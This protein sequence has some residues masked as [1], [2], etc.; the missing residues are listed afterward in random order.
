V[1]SSSTSRSGELAA[2]V[3]HALREARKGFQHPLQGPQ[4][5]PVGAG[6]GGHHQVLPHLQVGEDAAPFRHIRHAHA[7]DPVRAHAG[8]VAAAQ[9]DAASARHQVAEDRAQQGRLAHA[10]ASQ[11]AERRAG[12]YAEAGAAQHV[13]G[14]VVGVHVARG[15]QRRHIASAR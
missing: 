6:T 4:A 2:A 12:R 5:A 14:S 8:H 11:Q 3:V 15:D 10:V 9:V 1:A 13:A 7:R